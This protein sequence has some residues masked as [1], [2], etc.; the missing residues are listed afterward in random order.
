MYERHLFKVSNS[1][2][3]AWKE[4]DISGRR[5]P[6]LV[7]RFPTKYLPTQKRLLNTGDAKPKLEAET[8]STW[9][10]LSASQGTQIE[11]RTQPGRRLMKQN[12]PCG[13]FW[14]P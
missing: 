2:K 10:A 1:R 9:A 11:L 12:K 4:Q 8:L 6:N 3:Q 7:T 14:H 13:L 5:D